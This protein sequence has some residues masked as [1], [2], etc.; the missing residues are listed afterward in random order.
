MS[1][2]NHPN[3]VVLTQCT[4]VSLVVRGAALSAAAHGGLGPHGA[5]STMALLMRALLMLTCL[6][7]LF[8]VL[9]R[10]FVRIIYSTL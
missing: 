1:Q 10:Y 2:L 4:A 3:E 8:S 7:R 9:Y 6:Q 5:C